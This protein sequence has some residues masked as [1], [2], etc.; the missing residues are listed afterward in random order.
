[1]HGETIKKPWLLL[2]EKSGKY[3]MISVDEAIMQIPILLFQFIDSFNIFIY[4]G[5]NRP[6]FFSL[7]KVYWKGGWKYS[8]KSDYINLF[9]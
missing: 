5:K 4:A 7:R 2:T 3:L 6:P 8:H 1:M 9:V